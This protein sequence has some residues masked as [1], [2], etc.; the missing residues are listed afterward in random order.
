MPYLVYVIALRPFCISRSSTCGHSRRNAVN[1][2][3]CLQGRAARTGADIHGCDIRPTSMCTG[4]V[5]HAALC[6]PSAVHPVVAAAVGM[7]RAPGRGP[8]VKRSCFWHPDCSPY[9]L[10]QN[11]VFNANRQRV[12][13]ALCSPETPS[14]GA[15]GRHACA[16]CAGR[17]GD[18]QVTCCQ[19]SD[20]CLTCV[21]SLSIIICAFM[22]APS[23]GS[24]AQPPWRMFRRHSRS[25]ISKI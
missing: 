5:E 7:C 18:W 2:L 8:G 17:E 15:R 12:C 4:P 19:Q 16:H 9:R 1:C 13:N 6:S 3:G 25:K 14:C 22:K 24:L 20:C 11:F 10:R 23:T 21:A